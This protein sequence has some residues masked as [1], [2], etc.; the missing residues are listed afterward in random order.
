MN[1]GTLNVCIPKKNENGMGGT[2]FAT[3]RLR[4][5]PYILHRG[6]GLDFYLNGQYFF[7]I[8]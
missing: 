5:Q 6:K 7:T 1:V 3:I 2:D 4:C 8:E